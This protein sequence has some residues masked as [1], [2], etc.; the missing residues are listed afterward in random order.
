M[1]AAAGKAGNSHDKISHPAGCES[2]ILVAAAKDNKQV[3]DFS[4]C[5]EHLSVAGPGVGVLSLWSSGNSAHKK[6]SGRS[7]TTPHLACSPFSKVSAPTQ[8]L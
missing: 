8:L 1:V 4:A 2:V 7:M 5:N 3:A 6:L